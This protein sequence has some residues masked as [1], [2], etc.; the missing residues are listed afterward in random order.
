MGKSYLAAI[1]PPL[2]KINKESWKAD[3]SRN[4]EEMYSA[5]VVRPKPGGG[6]LLSIFVRRGCA[7]FQ[8]IVFRLFVLEQ[9][10]KRRQI[11]WSRLSKHVKRGNFVTKGYYLVKFLFF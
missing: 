5:Y 1:L 2:L 11:S 7:V 6:G 8:G 9:G 10:I 4:L 3:I